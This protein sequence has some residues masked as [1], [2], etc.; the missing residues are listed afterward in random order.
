[1]KTFTYAAAIALLTASAAF[2]QSSPNNGSMMNNATP[3]PTMSGPAEGNGGPSNQPTNLKGSMVQ[4]KAGGNDMSNN[5]DMGKSSSKAMSHQTSRDNAK[6][7]HIASNKGMKSGER[8]DDAQANQMTAQ[9]NQGQLSG[10]GM[11]SNSSANN[12]AAMNGN[13]NSFDNGRPQAAQAGGANCSPDNPS[14]GTARQN[15][16][17]NSSPQHRLEN[18]SP[19]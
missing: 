13:G 4:P 19:E 14:C 15:P 16:A 9:L 17:I 8:R 18:S 12:G 6:A 5:S 10:N 2:A 11:M 7:K 3:T 1:M